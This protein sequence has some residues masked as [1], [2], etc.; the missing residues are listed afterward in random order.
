MAH[1]TVAP[2][3]P[4]WSPEQAF[5]RLQE[6]FASKQELATAQAAEILLRKELVRFYF[7]APKEGTNRIDIGGGF[8]LRLQHSLTRKIDE[9]AFASVTARDIKKHKLDIDKLVEHVPKLKVTEFRNLTAEQEAF[10]MSFL[11]ISEGSPQLAIVQREEV[12]A[13]SPPPANVVPLPPGIAPSNGVA[14]SYSEEATKPGEFFKDEDGMWWL[15]SEEEWLVVE[16]PELLARLDAACGK[17]KRRR[18]V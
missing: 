9:A 13:T 8:D 16:E 7:T 12:I 11:D 14:I 2:N 4:D 10:V 17:P 18:K 3:K 1:K 15:L 6:W 5:A